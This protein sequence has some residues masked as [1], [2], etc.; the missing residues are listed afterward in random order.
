MD[1][2]KQAEKSLHNRQSVSPGAQMLKSTSAIDAAQQQ[3]ALALDES[4]LAVSLGQH[5]SPS[6]L[7]QYNMPSDEIR[8]QHQHQ[9]Y[10]Q[11]YQMQQQQFQNQPQYQSMQ[12]QLQQHHHMQFNANDH[13]NSDDS[14]DG[15]SRGIKNPN[16]KGQFHIQTFRR[17][18][19]T[20]F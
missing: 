14:N 13:T 15:Q 17:I 20:N 2:S 10:H 11:H 12:Q 1:Y 4:H 3:K 8:Q 9:M 5:I 18:H 6:Q 16:R 7:K 19:F